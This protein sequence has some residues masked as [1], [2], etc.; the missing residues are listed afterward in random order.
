[1]PLAETANIKKII[2]L[3]KEAQL[4]DDF[5]KSI[6]EAFIIGFENISF[7]K[8]AVCFGIIEIFIKILIEKNNNDT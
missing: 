2:D 4:T 6:L 7:R 8:Q 3:L 1:M 5:K